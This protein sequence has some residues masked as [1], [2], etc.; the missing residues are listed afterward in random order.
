MKRTEIKD[1]KSKNL[2]DL[3]KKIQE[4]KKELAEILIEKSLG[5]LKNVHKVHSKKKE[6]AQTLTFVTQK[7]FE[8]LA[9]KTEKS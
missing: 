9:V 7:K 5:K 4:L 3:V 6:I 1:L 2:K 8:S